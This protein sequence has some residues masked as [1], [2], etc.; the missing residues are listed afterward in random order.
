[1]K[2]FAIALA[3]TGCSTHEESLSLRYA[4]IPTAVGGA[5]LI[6]APPLNGDS[7]GRNTTIGGSLLIAAAIAMFSTSFAGK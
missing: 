1:M 2:R 6:A 7:L 4:S 3:L 5:L